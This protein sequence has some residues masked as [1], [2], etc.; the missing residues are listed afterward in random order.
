LRE[1]YPDLPHIAAPGTVDGGDVCE[2]Q[3][4]FIIGVS[5]RTNEAGAAQLAGHLRRLGYTARIVDIRPVQGL[6]HLKTGIAYV[7]DGV[8]VIAEGILDTVRAWGLCVSAKL[9]RVPGAEAY[10]ANCVRVNDAVLIARGYPRLDDALRAEG[11]RPVHLQMSEFR[12]MDG[13]LSC[14]SL[15]F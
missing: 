3:D 11:L 9:I 15:R 12:K 1:Y 10:A 4:G 14:L 7:G 6:L 5:L 8:W 2:A 13:G